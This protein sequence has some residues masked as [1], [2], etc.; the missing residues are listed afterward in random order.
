MKAERS[1]CAAAS[2]WATLAS[3][4]GGAGRAA[5]GLCGPGPS[6]G[7]DAGFVRSP[8]SGW[9]TGAAHFH[10]STAVADRCGERK[11]WETSASTLASLKR[12]AGRFE[13][14][15]GWSDV[16]LAA[17]RDRG[18]VHVIIWSHNG[19][20][21][22]LL[23]LSRWDE[24]RGDVAALERLLDDPANALD[25]ND[26]RPPFSSTTRPSWA[27]A[28]RRLL[29]ASRVAPACSQGLFAKSAA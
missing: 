4:C 12:L 19:R 29:N 5:G 27:M 20:A 23:C 1:P 18:I 9:E 25:A 17:S 22:D 6:G 15:I 10:H 21:R 7:A 8:R 24:P 2:A 26:N 14:A 11:T 3:E 13:G 16:T 28:A